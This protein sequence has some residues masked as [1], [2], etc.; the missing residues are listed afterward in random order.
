MTKIRQLSQETIK[1]IAAGEVIDR[2]ESIVKEA[3][4]NSI[5]AGSTSIQIDIKAGGKK[6][7]R[8]SDNGCG[9]SFEDLDYVFEKHYTS[10]IMDFND[11]YNLKSCGF[12][13]EA[14]NSIATVSRASIISKEESSDKAY[15]INYNYGKFVEKTEAVSNKGTTLIVEDLFE[16]MPVRQKL[17]ASDRTEENRIRALVERFAIGYPGIAFKFFS[18]SRL[19]L[20][21]SGS[22]N[23]KTAIF[24]VF[25]K[26]IVKDM[27]EIDEDGL[28]GF[29]SNINLYSNNGSNQM[30]FI[31]NRIV[32]NEELNNAVETQYFGKIPNSK[33]PLFFLF[34]NIEREEVDVNIHPSKK[35]VKILFTD[36]IINKIKNSVREVLLRESEYKFIESQDDTIEFKV[37]N[38]NEDENEDVVFFDTPEV[39]EVI[40]EDSKN[41]ERDQIE[42][43]E[44][45]FIQNELN[46][47]VPNIVVADPSNEY[48]LEETKYNLGSIFP[49]FE[50]GNFNNIVGII[51]KKYLIVE[52]RPNNL[53]IIVDLNAANSRLIFDL[54]TD[55]INQ[56][57]VVIQ[58]I[59]EPIIYK[60]DYKDAELI[61]KN[62]DDLVKSGFDITAMSDDTFIL[63]G[64][65][66]IIS[67]IFKKDDFYEIVKNI[68]KD[69]KLVIPNIIRRISI[70]SSHAESFFNDH[71]SR[72]ILQNVLKSSNPYTSPNGNPVFKILTQDEFLKRFNYE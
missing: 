15:Q 65:P 18:N 26:N 45:L 21:T 20:N 30:F 36:N 53:A 35:Y 9:I 37:Y 16:N 14:L 10:K 58:N 31:N 72:I 4:E 25:G 12:R 33:K 29:I 5:D 28:Y 61:N 47:S 11:I 50:I 48:D 34:L 54:Y 71:S 70:I 49:D 67:D 57:K 43:N 66:M 2:P 62:L 68:S 22:G 42:N 23:L 52:N 17:L 69:K 32:Y 40:K 27:L 3:V 19:V 1:K 64:I 63:R 13:G 44:N 7:I 55:D 6:H 24:E 38:S 8:I 46:I 56:N 51:F 41:Y 39:I 60:F 59:M